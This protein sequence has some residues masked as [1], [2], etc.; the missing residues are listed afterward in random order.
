MPLKSQT[1]SGKLLL[2]SCRFKLQVANKRNGA[3]AGGARWQRSG[4]FNLPSPFRRREA[5]RRL[6][7]TR[8]G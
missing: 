5:W 1:H 6:L 8:Q 3:S 4:K 2:C 7:Q